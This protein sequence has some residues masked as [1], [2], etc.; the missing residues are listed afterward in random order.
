MGKPIS[1]TPKIYESSCLT[2]CFNGNSSHH[3]CTYGA[4]RERCFAVAQDMAADKM[5]ANRKDGCCKWPKIDIAIVPNPKYPGTY[6]IEDRSE[7]VL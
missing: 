4:T 3:Y 1:V 7:L 6:M 2:F 5:E